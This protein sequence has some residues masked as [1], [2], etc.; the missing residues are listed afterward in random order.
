MKKYL[1]WAA[2]AFVLFFLFTNPTGAATIVDNVLHGLNTA[3][4]SLSTFV[5]SL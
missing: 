2:I 3:A 1:G 4:H 5:T